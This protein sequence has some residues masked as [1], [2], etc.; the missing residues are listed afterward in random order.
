MAEKVWFV[1]GTSSG[2]GHALV[3]ELIAKKQR[4]VATARHVDQ[5]NK[6]QQDNENVYT[7]SLDVT[8]HDNVVRTV[9]EAID[10]FGRIDVLVNNAG[11]GYFGSV[12]ESEESVVRAM[13]DT[14]FWGA[15]D[16][17]RTV[18]PVFRKQASG[19]IINISSVGGITGSPAFGFYNASKFALEGLSSALA[20]E[21]APLGI[22]VTNVEP[23]PFRTDWAGR[24]HKS[25]AETIDD[26]QQTAHTASSKI[27]ALSGSQVGSPELAA[28]AIIKLSTLSQPPFHFLT[29]VNAYQRAIQAYE[30]ALTEFKKYQEDSSHID[31][32]DEDYWA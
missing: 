20:K 31:Y 27:E 18:L 15:A 9:K 3:E 7:S 17:I 24:S 5:I 25:A 29:G 1:T 19:H 21:V 8:D 4:V 11:W 30:E 2:F 16:V 6:W 22:H 28:K 13:M 10:H 14:N 12:E 26:Y 23:G 32:G